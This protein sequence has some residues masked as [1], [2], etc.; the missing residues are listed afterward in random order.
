M[1]ILESD[2]F[3]NYEFFLDEI[4]ERMTVRETDTII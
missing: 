2:M 1:D 3:V 4:L